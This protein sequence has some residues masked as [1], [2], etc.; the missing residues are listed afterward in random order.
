V[1]V[2]RETRDALSSMAAA[3]ATTYTEAVRRAVA[4]YAYI[5]EQISAGRIVQTIKTDGTDIRELVLL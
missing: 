1:N 5:E 3:N 4:V 2:N